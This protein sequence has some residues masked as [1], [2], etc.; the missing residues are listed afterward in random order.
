MERLIQR[1]WLVGGESS[2]HMV[3]RD[4]TSTGDG[5]VSALQVL[6]ALSRA[7][8]SLSEVRSGMSKLPQKMINVRV[9]TR[10]DPMQRSDI[11][12]AMRK[13]EEKLGSS[14][15][16]L[17]RASGTEPLIRVMAE[18]Q[19]ESDITQVVEALAVVVENS[20]A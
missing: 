2:G 20:K 18:G 11:Q 3:I 19:D 6:L 5:I 7:D 12:A 8:K 15:R 10:F 14:G 16:I 13:A 9:E 4:C 17:L 1:N